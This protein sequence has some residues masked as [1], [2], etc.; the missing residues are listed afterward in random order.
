MINLGKVSDSLNSVNRGKLAASVV[1]GGATGFMSSMVANSCLLEVSINGFFTF[2]FFIIL[3]VVGGLMIYRNKQR[4]DQANQEPQNAEDTFMRDEK[5]QFLKYASWVVVSSGVLCLFLEKNWN[6][7]FPYILKTPIYIIVGM[8]LN[9]L[10]TFALVDFINFGASYV[11]RNSTIQA[12]E[13]DDQVLALLLNCFACGMLYGLV[14]SL[15]DVED[16]SYNQIKQRFFY[17]EYFCLPIGVVGG[18]I[19][20]AINEV[21]RCNV[22]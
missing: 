17:E 11:Q 8:A 18:A 13:S 10:I 19:G 4:E 14:F 20:G 2:Y 9:Y 5:K 21:L 1:V 22:I 6:Q 7:D 16:A 3:S 12:V 15:M